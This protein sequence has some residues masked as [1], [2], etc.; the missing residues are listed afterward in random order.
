L[1]RQH[2]RK[3]FTCREAKV[4]DWLQTKALQNQEKRLAATK[5]LLEADRIAGFYTVAIGE[6][7]FDAAPEEVQKRLPRRRLPIALLAWMGVHADLRGQRLGARIF[8]IALRDCF[9]AGKSLPFVAVVIDCISEASLTFFKKWDCTAVE[10]SP[11]R[12]FLSAKRLE[13]MMVG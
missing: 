5:V 6:V 3:E 4:D 7:D 12:L 2:R 8:A 13:A 1:N 10:N 9:E 11:N